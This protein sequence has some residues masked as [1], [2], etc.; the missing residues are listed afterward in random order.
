M[1]NGK[2]EIARVLGQGAFGITYLA[3]VQIRAGL[4]SVETTGYVAIKEFFIGEING[5][6]GSTVT[7]GC[8]AKLF[9]EYK[10]KF[11]REA[12]NLSKLHHDNIIRVFDVFEANNTAYYVM[13]Y[14][15]G[16][17]LDDLI[18]RHNGL[19]EGETLKYAAQIGEALR[20]MHS[21]DMLHLKLMPSN[22]MLKNGKAIVTDFGFSQLYQEDPQPRI[23]IGLIPGYNPL[24][25]VGY[26]GHNRNYLPVTMDVYA[27]G[28]TM[29]KM[30][31]G[32]RPADAEYILIEGFPADD[33]YA[34]GVSNDLIEL[35]SKAMEPIKKKRIQTMEEIQKKLDLLSGNTGREY[36]FYDGD[37]EK[38]INNDLPRRAYKRPDKHPEV[39][40]GGPLPIGLNKT[41]NK[42]WMIVIFIVIAVSIIW[43]VK[44]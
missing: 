29:F 32:H 25:Q 2:Y 21:H 8:K 9:D 22:V 31:T 40:Y 19:S 1:Q 14:L 42:I 36:I 12:V 28:A 17:S 10:R 34:K 24:E 39:V 16:G 35:I 11:V 27:F 23:P 20:F 18:R 7:I 33:L 43:I 44:F 30:L 5:R 6:E 3:A 38:G 15:D 26:D 13:E 41:S 4:D 37:T